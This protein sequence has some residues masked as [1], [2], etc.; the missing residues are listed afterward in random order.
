MG[1]VA[2]ITIRVNPDVDA[3][4]HA[5]I[6]TGKKENKFGIPITRASEVYAEAARLPGLKV[7]GIDVH[8]GSQLTELEPFEQAFTKVADLTRRLRAEG[9]DIRRLD[10]GGGLGIPYTRGNEAP[11]LPAQYGAMIKRTVGDLGCEI[12]IEPGRLISGNAGILVSRVI[13]VKSGEERE[14]LIVDAAM[15][16]LVRPSMY[17]A[18]HDIVPVIEPAPGLETQTYDVVG[19]VCE[20]GDTFARARPMPRLAPGARVAILEAGAYGA[21]MGSTYNSR[22]L[23]AIAMVDG[24]N[25]A[26]IRARQSI[27]AIWAGETVPDF[28]G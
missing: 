12:E 20:T 5:K 10:L 8:I 1:V 6:A 9:H 21:V 26:T 28:L 25:W 17:D 13:Y 14:F 3:K 18:H 4:T 2:P 7:V 16:D 23:P 24:G 19:P 15:N 27:E 22:T 11:P